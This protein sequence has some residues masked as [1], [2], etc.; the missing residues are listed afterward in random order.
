VNAVTAPRMFPRGLW[1]VGWRYLLRHR[2]Q[3]VLMV[4]G[5]ALGVAVMVAIDLANASASRAFT[6]STESITGKA[7]YQVTGSAL[8]LDEKV[9]TTL[10]RNVG[11]IPMAPV[12]SEYGESPQ[13]G[14][15]PLQLLGIDPFADGAFRPYLGASS[16]LSQDALTAF[17]TRPG[18]VLLEHDLASRYGL[19]L[20]SSFELDID[21]HPRQVFVAGLLEASDDLQKRTLDGTILADISTAQELTAR[22]GRIDW[23]DLLIP[24]GNSADVQRI[25]SLLPV[26][27]R[28]ETVAARQGAVAQM[29]SAFQ[30]NLTMLSLL[31]LIVGLFL[32]YNTMTFSVVQRRSLFGTLRCLGVTR[33]EVF[34][35][36][37]SEALI[38]G[39]LGSGLGIGLGVLM[40]RNTVG[41][42]TQT[43]NDL[44]F[45]TTV[46]ATGIP[47]ASLI[48]GAVA[49][50]LA[51]V[52][53]AGFP[54]WE[55]ASVPP[56]AALS[57]SGLETKTRRLVVVMAAGGAGTIGLGLAAFSIPQAN[58]LVGFG[59]TAA[60]VVGFAM[61][62]A[63]AMVAILRGIGPL[64]ERA[65]GLLGRMAPR[66]LVASLS[67]TA[68]AV[69]AL[70][71]AVAVTVGVTLMIDS[72]RYTVTIWLAQ[73]LQGDVYV[74]APSF[75]Q[76]GSTTGIDPAAV[77]A[78]Q[79]WPGVQRADLLR[80]VMVE[81]PQGQ[82]QL[83]ATDN[84]RIGVER[85]FMWSADPPEQVWQAMQQGSVL[86]SEPLA[87]RYG[88]LAKG[89]HLTLY[90]PAG[91][92]VFPVEGVYYDYASSEG[93]LFMAMD[94]YRPAWQDAG[95][96]AIGLRLKPGIDADSITRQL[97]DSLAVDQHL[98]IR[99]NQVLRNEVM[100]VFDRTFAITAALRI[101]ATVVAFIGVLNTLLL[102]QLE[103]QREVGI[104][105]AL[106]LSGGQLWRLTML[107]TG[108]MGL[109]AG[110]LAAPTGYAL[111]LILV[112]I[113]NQRSFGWT[114]QL[115]IQPEAFVQALVVAVAAALLAG[116]YPAS[117]MSRQPAAEAIRYE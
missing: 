27:V 19:G 70:M 22:V 56:Q 111:A 96:T 117:R 54:A 57:R 48:K 99:P 24:E 101:L 33:T 76:T 35:L 13:L 103:K 93:A 66:N 58:L 39:I 50:I 47:L 52:L 81:T 45:T 90:T 32:I 2:W 7:T 11:D 80:T 109:A 38:V 64:M 12:I 31:A 77:K 59:G 75:T 37:I 29:T 30:L 25:Q 49:G 26:G 3:S 102:L 5:I 65:F 100:S 4:L 8:G 74:T 107:E 112:Y 16:G 84:P 106:G 94:V 83:S 43:I 44:Y 85:L 41:M 78:I 63:L 89:S 61:L 20:G 68:V 34:G 62:A 98:L 1:N 110:L 67:R 104:L 46:N 72:F 17:L 105:R 88:L 114:L 53:T 113:I 10:H 18:A 28:V 51:T 21:G 92:R 82:V 97:Q 40:G 116:I 108:L 36:V 115:S 91:P 60:V 69:A 9:Y 15:N 73:T 23:I 87:R 6:L 79:G 71:V 86:I 95:V 42:V 14:G 55:A